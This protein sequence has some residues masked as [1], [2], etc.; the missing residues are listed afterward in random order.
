MAQSL[1]LVPFEPG[2]LW[3]RIVERSEQALRSGAIFPIATSP[4]FVSAQGARFLVR[5]V[6]QLERK[7]RARRE[8]PPAARGV[9]PF[10]PFDERMFVAHVSPTHV[11]LL[12]KFN[13]LEHHALVVTRAWEPQ[14]ALLTRRDFEALWAC[15]REFPSLGFY[16][17]GAEAGASQAHK[18]LQVVPVPLWPSDPDE[19]KPAPAGAG[20]QPDLPI[21]PLLRT[22]TFDRPVTCDGLPF[23]HCL[24]RFS[25]SLDGSVDG[26]AA[27]LEDLYRSMLHTLAVRRGVAAEA[28]PYN[29]LVTRRV[30]LLVPRSRE[31]A[32]GMSIN[33]LGFA[34]AL[35]VRNDAE[36][37][38]V[39]EHGPLSILQAVGFPRSDGTG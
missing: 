12:N 4:T 24:V 31:H 3:R 11:C 39:E 16:N 25:R 33:A 1:D 5:V 2:S 32:R 19:S 22:A 7:D 23:D 30:L 20:I 38:A 18:H 6:S 21:D 37:R 15:M 13:V 36:L 14:E 9:N 26:T 8:S 34:G 28:L 10:L 35:L 29:L 17:A 27:R